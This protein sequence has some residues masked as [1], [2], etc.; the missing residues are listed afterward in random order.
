MSVFAV[1][2]QYVP[3]ADLVN[4]I[5]PAHRAWLQEQLDGGSL[6]ASGPLVDYPGA[7]LVWR[8]ES[9]EAVNELLNQDPFDIAGLIDEREIREWLPVFGPFN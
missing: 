2:Y 8:A 7:L 9:V 1:Q 3:D 6:L 5:R 4:A